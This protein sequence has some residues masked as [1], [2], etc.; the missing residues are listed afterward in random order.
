V[1]QRKEEQENKHRLSEIVF[2]GFL[3]LFLY[4]NFK[5]KF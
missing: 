1:R 2:L 3:L 5:N 4:V